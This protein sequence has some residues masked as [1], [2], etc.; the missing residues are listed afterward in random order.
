M[1]KVLLVVL[2]GALTLSFFTGCEDN[3][4][5]AVGQEQEYTHKDGVDAEVKLPK[6]EGTDIPIE[7]PV[8]KEPPASSVKGPDTPTIYNENQKP[9]TQNNNRQEPAADKTS[10]IGEAAAKEIA[11]KKAG[12]NASQVVFEK[13]QLDRDDGIWQYEIEF[14]QNN[15][16]YD[17]DV[18]ADDGKILSFEKDID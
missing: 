13:A 15:I 9:S 16:E 17:V 3:L 2:A 5:A 1:K 10:F 14:R 4:K 6:N 12:L 8:D 18:K 7:K 11:L